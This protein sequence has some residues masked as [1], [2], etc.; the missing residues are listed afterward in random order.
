MKIEDNRKG[1]ELFAT[2]TDASISFG[3]VVETMS[4]AIYLVVWCDDRG[5][6]HNANPGRKGLLCLQ[7]H[8]PWPDSQVSPTVRKLNARLVIDRE[9]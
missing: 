9:P 3:D 4:G 7:T 8:K 5:R 6:P 1:S 2:L